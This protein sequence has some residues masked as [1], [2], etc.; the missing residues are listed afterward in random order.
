MIQ[1]PG[2]DIEHSRQSS[3]KTVHP[4]IEKINDYIY[5][6]SLSIPDYIER[7]MKEYIP[8]DFRTARAI[9]FA[10]CEPVLRFCTAAELERVAAARSL[11]RQVEW[12]CGRVILKNLLRSVMFPGLNFHDIVVG[13]DVSGKPCIKGHKNISVSVTHSGDVAMAALHVVPGKRIGIDVERTG[14]IDV[15]A[16]LSVAFS[17]EERDIYNKKSVKEIISAFTMKEAYLKVTGQGFHE[18]ITRVA[19]KTG[20]IFYNGL[21]VKELGAVTK[22]YNEEYV[23]SIIFEQ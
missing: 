12:L 1:K 21:E 17:P 7:S 22:D 2:K 10:E 23:F 9:N 19:V 8:S 13:Y 14:G 15:D 18:V 3:G 6:A 11:K 5:Y 20:N 4:A 16:V